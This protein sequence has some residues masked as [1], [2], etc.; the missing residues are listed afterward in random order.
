ML[1]KFI[2]DTILSN[3]ILLKILVTFSSKIC[4]MF[5]NCI[6]EI[7]FSPLEVL[8]GRFCCYFSFKTFS[9]RIFDTI[10]SKLNSVTKLLQS[11]F[12]IIFTMRFKIDIIW[13]VMLIIKY[14][15]TVMH[16]KRKLCVYIFCLDFPIAYKNRAIVVIIM[17]WLKDLFLLSP[18]FY[19]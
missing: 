11:L 15:P 3:Y 8:I 17:S 4:I 10:N 1:K 7:F 5:S 18:V 16:G 19:L 9:P 12:L 14:S 2:T 6:H 13:I